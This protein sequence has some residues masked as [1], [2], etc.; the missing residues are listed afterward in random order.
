MFRHLCLL[1]MAALICVLVG[2][3][4]CLPAYAD[5]VRITLD[6]QPVEL[7]QPLL[8][9]NGTNLVPLAAICDAM[10]AKVD[11]NPQAREATVT[12]V[13]K[14]IVFKPGSTEVINNGQTL[15]TSPSRII[16][17][18]LWVSLRFLSFALGYRV[19]WDEV[20]GAINIT[21]VKPRPVFTPERVEASTFPAR[22][23]FT[24]N[25]QLWLLDGSQVGSAPLKLKTANWVEIVGWSP[26]GKWLAYQ[27]ADVTNS[28][29]P[30]KK[31]LCV[32]KVDGTGA[33]RIE[34]CLDY[35]AASWSPTGD[36]I[37][38]LTGESSDSSFVYEIKIASIENDKI[39]SRALYQGA[40]GEDL[41]FT[42][43]PSG[44]SL[45]VTLPRT[46][47]RPIT[48]QNVNLEGEQSNLLTLGESGV[49]VDEMYTRKASFPKWSPDGR[50]LAYH[51][52]LNSGSLSADEVRC[53]VL[54]T[55]ENKTFDL[56]NGLRYPEW[57]SW[58]PDSS[59]LAYIQGGGR[60]AG[61]NKQLTWLDLS[62]YQLTNCGKTG[63]ADTRPA[64]LSGQ[65]E[66]VLF[67]RGKENH[68]SNKAI[69][70]EEVLVE[71]QRIWLRGKDGQ[72]AALTSGPDNTA[73]YNPCPSAD[74]KT[75][76]FMRLNTFY[77]GSLYAQPLSGGT[78]QELVRGISGDPGYYG[79]YLPDWFS[80]Y[81]LK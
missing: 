5:Q 26:D 43:H 58:S 67:C 42:W 72:E 76:V 62:S 8:L 24:S 66:G 64:M 13:D 75:L 78:E 21:T 32:V 40:P 27:E 49:L 51:L 9:E 6:G 41:D 11:W 44:Q 35:A 69:E 19:G 18:H 12:K 38:Y 54:D 79:N 48:I 10:G 57:I 28:G 22:I 63:Q 37:A 34:E 4:W 1:S 46:R 20:T 29:Y 31:Y 52:Q 80:I 3:I 2:G 23:A 47:L 65:T 50:Y 77:S 59:H 16:D 68:Y 17:G 25:H 56:P 14:S 81:W 73:D 70:A 39:D 74:G 55:K 30:D 36:A 53:R 15:N 60:D 7:G 45:T 61:Y 71:G 33:V